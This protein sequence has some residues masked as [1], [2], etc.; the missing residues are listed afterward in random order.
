MW[1]FR[2]INEETGEEYSNSYNW[3]FISAKEEIVL[4][5]ALFPGTDLFVNSYYVP[6][7]NSWVVFV[8]D[9]YLFDGEEYTLKLLVARNGYYTIAGSVEM[10]IELFTIS[11]PAYLYSR[12][13]IL[14]DKQQD[15]LGSNGLRE[16]IP[17]YT[18][19]KGGYGLLSAT[20]RVDRYVI[21]LSQD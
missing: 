5:N 20:Q 19:V 16:P 13:K 11:E 21:H 8:F 14:Q 7:N 10:W 3:P 12:S 18:N 1:V 17:T 9:D 15:I 6:Y 2:Y 4:E